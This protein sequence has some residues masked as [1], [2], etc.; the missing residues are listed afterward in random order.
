MVCGQVNFWYALSHRKLL[1]QKNPR[2]LIPYVILLCP[3][4]IFQF[5]YSTCIDKLLMLLGSL[6]ATAH[7]AA[8]PA[9]IIVFGD[10]TDLFV[11][12]GLFA[13]FLESIRS[14]LPTLGL[15]YDQVYEY[16]HVLE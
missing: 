2:T 14:Y 8:L 5:K 6:F 13:A 7:G 11:E 9:M 10:M 3:F 12:S 4:T 15:T 16:P 1:L